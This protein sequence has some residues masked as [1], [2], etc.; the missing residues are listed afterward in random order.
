MCYS[1]RVREP[2]KASLDWKSHYRYMFSSN[3]RFKVNMRVINDAPLAFRHN[4][5]RGEE[6]FVNDFEALAR[7]RESVRDEYFDFQPIASQYLRDKR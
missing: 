1:L 2:E 6:L 3:L 4:V 5:S 7:F